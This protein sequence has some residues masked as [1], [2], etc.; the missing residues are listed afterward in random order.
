[1]AAL[2][3]TDLIA[4]VQAHMKTCGWKDD[5]EWTIGVA[6]DAAERL[7]RHGQDANPT[8]KWFDAGSDT[9]AS[10]TVEWLQTNFPR[11]NGE[12][13]SRKPKKP[14]TQVYVFRVRRGERVK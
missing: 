9:A 1:M 7:K 3:R 11:L 13:A 4:S 5:K 2:V 6:E 14:P 10:A 8:A 12:K